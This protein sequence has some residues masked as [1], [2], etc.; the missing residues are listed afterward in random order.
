MKFVRTLE[1]FFPSRQELVQ[2]ATPP[3]QENLKVLTDKGFKN[4]PPPSRGTLDLRF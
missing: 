3:R 4:L 2:P 1:V